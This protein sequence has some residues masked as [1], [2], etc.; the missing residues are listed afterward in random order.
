MAGRWGRGRYATVSCR[1][2]VRES[3]SFHT[4]AFRTT[5]SQLSLFMDA[6]H[7]L[8]IRQTADNRMQFQVD[9]ADNAGS[10]LRMGSIYG[11]DPA[12]KEDTYAEILEILEPGTYLSLHHLLID[13]PDSHVLLHAEVANQMPAGVGNHRIAECAVL[14]SPRIREIVDRRGI[15]LLSYRDI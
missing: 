7:E 1:L 10:A 5:L 11:T 14:T 13:A 8:S 15:E 12:M 4:L 3:D 6:H 2:I 9:Q